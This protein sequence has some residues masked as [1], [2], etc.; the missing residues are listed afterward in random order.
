MTDPRPTSP[1]EWIEFAHKKLWQATSV[2]NAVQTLAALEPDLLEF[3][4]TG[5]YDSTR[6]S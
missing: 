2:S 3:L 1:E 6:W 4:M 5:A